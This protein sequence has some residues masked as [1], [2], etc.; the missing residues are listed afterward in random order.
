MN[1][2]LINTNSVGGSHISYKSNILDTLTYSLNQGIKCCQFFL[3][4]PRGFT[5]SNISP[6]DIIESQRL[7]DRFSMKCFSHSPYIYNLCGDNTEVITKNLEY[8]I[9]ILGQ[10]GGGVV[11]HPGSHINVELGIN[12][13][14][15]SLN[16][17][18][19]PQ[20]GLLLLENCAG[21][22]HSLGK[23]FRELKAMLNTK[24]VEHMGICLDTAHI[25]GVG[26]YN[27]SK[28]SE[29]DRMF[30]EFDDIIGIHML[31]L[32]HLND[33]KVGFGSKKDR[34]ELIGE[35][36]IWKNNIDTLKYF[37]QTIRNYGI[38]FILETQPTD[39]IKMYNLGII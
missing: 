39:Y 28:I 4:N 18:N 34:H 29:I 26:E 24:N 16:N 23:T 32:I 7:I 1:L 14:I 17:I 9:S 20:G 36:N 19:F 30:R 21:Q 6:S 13:I 25:W 33:S 5:R 11:L 38:P 2:I 27:I 8:E 31:K 10:L 22:G 15:E 37:L 12:K 35:G 3:G